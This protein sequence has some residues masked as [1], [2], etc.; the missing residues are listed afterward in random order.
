MPN[1]KKIEEK[2]QLVIKKDS[3]QTYVTG[4]IGGSS[5]VDIRLILLEKETFTDDRGNI[6]IRNIS[7]RQLVMSPPIAANIVEVLQKQL[8]DIIEKTKS[9]EKT[10]DN[11]PN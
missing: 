8:K 10:K 5:Q 9:Q 1:T 7:K 11:S 3:E 6:I 2:G 4:V